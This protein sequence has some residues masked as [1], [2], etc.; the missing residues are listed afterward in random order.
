MLSMKVLLSSVLRK[1][2]FTTVETK[3]ELNIGVVLQS[4]T[5]YI[6][7]LHRRYNKEHQLIKK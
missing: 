2:K 3:L 1:F 6:V 7:Q 5:G 4:K